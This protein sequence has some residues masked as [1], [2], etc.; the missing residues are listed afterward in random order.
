MSVLTKVLP[1]LH[2]VKVS[3]I[4]GMAVGIAVGA[5]V[6]VGGT[7]A[8]VM[9]NKANQKSDSEYENDTHTDL[10]N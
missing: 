6:G 8:V 9:L 2:W 10:P 4:A 3:F 5:C 1:M 7:V